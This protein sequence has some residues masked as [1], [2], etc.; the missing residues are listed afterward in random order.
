MKEIREAVNV[1]RRL[2]T[3]DP[4]ENFEKGD[5]L[6]AKNIVIYKNVGSNETFAQNL[7][8]TLQLT[9][10]IFESYHKCIG[11]IRNEIENGVFIFLC[12]TRT[13][14][15]TFNHQIVYYNGSTFSSIINSPNLAF[16]QNSSINGFYFQNNLIWVDGVESFSNPPRHLDLGG[17]NL[18][19]RIT[20]SQ[21][22]LIKTPPLPLLVSVVSGTL[23]ENFNNKTYQFTSR[24]IYKNG[25]KS[26]CGLVSE[27]ILPYYVTDTAES[28]LLTQNITNSTELSKAIEYIE[29]IVRDRYTFG[30]KH[31][32]KVP[33]PTTGNTVTFTF[34]DTGS[35]P[36]IPANEVDLWYDAVPLKSQTAVGVQN[37]ALFGN[38][39]EYYDEIPN[40]VSSTTDN[41]QTNLT[42]HRKIFKPNSKYK[43]A[44][45]LYDKEQ[46]SILPIS[47]ENLVIN[48][49]DQVGKVISASYKDIV[50]NNSA[51]N[52]TWVNNI[53][54]DI[55][56]NLN[57][58]NFLQARP[59]NILYSTGKDSADTPIFTSPIISTT[60]T[61]NSTASTQQNA[62]EKNEFAL[63]TYYQNEYNYKS[64]VNKITDAE[65]ASEIYID[66]DNFYTNDN[67][68][69]YQFN[70]GDRVRFLTTGLSD[71]PCDVDKKIK[72][73][74]GRFLVIDGDTS[75]NIEKKTA[76]YSFAVFP[77]SGIPVTY[78]LCCVKNGRIL[79]VRQSNNSVTEIYNNSDYSFNAIWVSPYQESIAGGFSLYFV[80][81]GDSG[82]ILNGKIIF[83]TVLNYTSS[84]TF[85]ANNTSTNDLYCVAI[86]K[87]MDNTNNVVVIGG[88]S[89]FLYNYKLP[90]VNGGIIGDGTVNWSSIA[91][92][93]ALSSNING[94]QNYQ[95]TCIDTS[96]Y[97][98]YDRTVN[99]TPTSTIQSVV[100]F[101]PSTWDI[102]DFNS[103]VVISN[104]KIFI[105]AGNVASG[106]PSSFIFII[107]NGS[108]DLRTD[109]QSPFNN[110]TTLTV[111]DSPMAYIT[112]VSTYECFSKAIGDF[113]GDNIGDRGNIH[114]VVMAGESASG[115]NYIFTGQFFYNAIYPTGLTGSALFSGQWGAFNA[116]GGG[117]ANSSTAGRINGLTKDVAGKI[118]WVKF[119]KGRSGIA[120]YLNSGGLYVSDV[121]DLIIGT[122][123]GSVYCRSVY[124]R[125]NNQQPSVGWLAWAALFFPN[126]ENSF[127][128]SEDSLRS[129]RNGAS[130]ISGALANV[131]GERTPAFGL[132]Y[133][134]V[135]Q[136]EIYN[137]NDRSQLATKNVY[138][139]FNNFGF[140]GSNTQSLAIFNPTA[141]QINVFNHGCL[142]EIYTPRK[143][144][145]ESILYKGVLSTG[146]NGGV[147]KYISNPSNNLTTTL[148]VGRDS[149]G[150]CFL[151]KKRFY[152]RLWFKDTWIV[153]MTPYTND[154]T[155]T[156]INQNTDNSNDYGWVKGNCRP[157][158]ASVEKQTQKKYTTGLRWSLPYTQNTT[159]NSLNS[160]N[161]T[162]TK[163]LPLENGAITKL[164]LATDVAREGG[165]VLAGMEFNNMS[166]Y[167]G[168]SMITQTDGNPIL[169][170]TNDFIGAMQVLAGNLGTT[171]TDS[172][173]KFQNLV[174]GFDVNKGEVW[175]YSQAGCN[176]ITDT[177]SKMFKYFK[178]K[179]QQFLPYKYD[180]NY[181]IV[182]FINTYRREY[183]ICFPAISGV[184]PAETV[185]Y[186][187]ELNAWVSYYDYYPD[188]VNYIGNRVLA[189]KNGMWEHESG[190]NFNV[191]YG[192][193]YEA[194]IK[195]VI[196]QEPTEQKTYLSH[197]SLGDLMYADEFRTTKSNYDDQF[198]YM[199]PIDYEKH[200]GFKSAG[201]WMNRNVGG[202]LND[203][204]LA[205]I[206]GVPIWGNTAQ[207]TLKFE[208]NTQ[209]QTCKMIKVGY[210]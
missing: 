120:T 50:I 98:T 3:D 14:P 171:H 143:T 134:L 60:Y 83:S 188:A 180:K 210:Y 86:N 91:N 18:T 15:A 142:I 208:N 129:Q 154:I 184:T 30:F 89:G 193:T 196:N 97:S 105:V 149:E 68:I 201:L 71:E 35:Y 152:G 45:T 186:N 23:N 168:K 47:N 66:V 135:G 176:S 92:N 157:S 1:F 146:F 43:L 77:N 52:N 125:G 26:R 20:P 166:L 16:N 28:I 12:D 48:T 9:G 109:I 159:L 110:T 182:S 139:V 137:F 49:Q 172:V 155:G 81:V 56:E 33:Y 122:D 207:L 202:T 93:L 34:K 190:N 46:R 103:E 62:L 38:N 156:Y 204:K 145:N 118:K 169:A 80:A 177:R 76:I 174:F 111:T 2:N 200:D 170:T 117:T 161:L 163:A 36:M 82:A 69:G 107:P 194:Y 124:G 108:S 119:S 131:S 95:F 4:L 151:I 209:Q 178:K 37:R 138:G 197:H 104:S 70:E 54:I 123:N 55:S 73:Q 150:D 72:R 128:P 75:F 126:S 206:N 13:N 106:N 187:F 58:T 192:T 19:D 32:D 189:Y 41:I 84:T 65:Q 175:Q 181:K 101:N 44:I 90:L 160:F 148:S 78:N 198:C 10:Y 158:I 102:G 173:R 57:V 162:D 121:L 6:D 22:T 51:I 53:G 140:A 21:L 165:V 205:Q 132:L 183:V 17:T 136:Q 42:T 179:G 100:K 8:S 88:D 153:S 133:Q 31:I 27:L 96:V 40:I 127:N 195:S 116:C 74:E 79:L 141:N 24:F 113:S 115:E 25:M 59:E 29:F 167:I 147:S 7:K 5:M 63:S 39:I 11:M 64:N 112:S 114:V 67:G 203:Q 144:T 164:E 94:Y 85:I 87:S 61:N 199:K 130:S 99:D 191:I 185:A